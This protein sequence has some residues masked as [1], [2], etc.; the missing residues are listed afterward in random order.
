[1]AQAP[2]I[3]LFYKYCSIADAP[4]EV[5]FHRSFCQEHNLFG[6]IL[7]STEGING[8]LCGSD[9]DIKA[10]MDL[11]KER[12]PFKMV[13]FDFKTSRPEDGRKDLFPDLKVAQVKEIISTG[14]VI[15]PELIPSKGGRHVSAQEWHEM[16]AQK[17]PNTVI[18]DVRNKDETLIGGFEGSIDP[19][20]NTFAF[21]PNFVHKE[22][23]KLKG[24]R[25]MMYCTGGIRC[26]KASA[27]LKAQGV[28]DV[29]QLH[30]GIH[31]YLEAYPDGGFWEGK[32]FVF[33]KRVTMQNKDYKVKG[34][35]Q[36][37]T[38]P[39]DNFRPDGV[40][41]VCHNLLLVCDTCAEGLHEF[42]CMDHWHLRKHYF[43]FVQGFSAEELRQ[44]RQALQTLLDSEEFQG[45]H[46]KQKR[47]TLRKQ[48][49]KLDARLKEME[50]CYI[51]SGPRYHLARS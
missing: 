1:M 42:H 21:Y 34:K 4:A 33:D 8:T 25:V 37:C 43:T 5:E 7:L 49:E 23:E 39:W 50:V 24:K 40:C 38:K 48:I 36:Y 15:D 14:G 41:T 22:A 13:D 47:K 9:A 11:L 32:N 18:I 51:L 12:E 6:R 19:D 30:G 20:M 35:C 26:E 28:D 10:Y 44:Q 17:D 29:H 2:L 3:I 31:R 27:Y 16:M 45:H 46:M